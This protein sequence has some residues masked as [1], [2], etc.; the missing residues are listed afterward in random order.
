MNSNDINFIKVKFEN[1]SKS[2][3]YTEMVRTIK[4]FKLRY[5]NNLKLD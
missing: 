4:G 2:I 1:P 3:Q 5:N